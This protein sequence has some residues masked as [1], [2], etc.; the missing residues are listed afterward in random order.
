[1]GH[2]VCVCENL[3]PS[4]PSSFPSLQAAHCCS[5]ASQALFFEWEGEQTT[6][7]EAT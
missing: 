5:K 6:P 3:P 4:A 2:G 1:M 7:V